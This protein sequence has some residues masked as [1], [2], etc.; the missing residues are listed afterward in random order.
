MTRIVVVVWLGVVAA[1]WAAGPPSLADARTRRLKGNTAEAREQFAA[2]LAD[3]ATRIAAAVGL[4]HCWES[5][6]EPEKARATID[7]AL[8]SGASADLWARS[9]ELLRAA[10]DLDAAAAAAEKALHLQPEHFAARWA[11]AQL[12]RDRGEY[13]KADAEYRWFVRTYV[14]RHRA[15]KDVRDPDE[16][17]IVAQAGAENAR[18]HNLADQFRFILNEVLA[19]ALRA[20]PSYWPAEHLAG[21]LLLEKHNKA[22]ALAA[23]DKAL[24]INPRSADA[25]VGKGRLA[26][27]QADPGEAETFAKRALAVNAR[28]PGALLLLADVYLACGDDDRAVEFLN[29]ARTVN[30]RDEGTLGRLAAVATIR[31]RPNVDA[32]ALRKEAEGFNPK[33]G[34]FYFEMARRLDDRRYYAAARDGYAKALELFPQ[35]TNAKAELG[36]LALRMGEEDRA[37]LLLSDAFKAD[38]FHAR[39]DSSLRVLRHLDKYKTVKTVHFIVRYDERQDPVLGLLLVERLEQE[40]DRLAKKFNHRPAG[41]FVVELFNSHE[42]FSGRIIAA[43]DLH[44]VGATTG[45]VVGMAS[46][47][48]KGVLKPF[49]WS[50]VIRHELTHIFNLDQTN[51]LVPHWLTE[52]LAV[53]NE[54]TPRPPDWLRLL[55]ARLAA[56]ELLTLDTINAGFTRPKSPDDWTLAYCQAQLYVE[57]L[58][59]RFGAE[60][61]ER[62]LK[63]FRAGLT[64]QD[65]LRRACGV[66]PESVESAYKSYVQKVVAEAGLPP[67]ERPLSLAQLEARRKQ[68]VSDP[69]IAAR[70]AEQY[71]RRKRVQEAREL[72]DAAVAKDPAH[73]LANYVRAQLL[74]DAGDVERAAEILESACAGDRP[75]ARS[76]R[77]LGVLH[78]DAGRLEEALAAFE[79][80]RKL[81]PGDPAWSDDIAKAARA[82]GEPERAA[83]AQ[84]TALHFAPDDIDGRRELARAWVELEKFSE[85][86]STA[87]EAIDIDPSDRDVQDLLLAALRRQG[88]SGE[89]DRWERLFARD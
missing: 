80:G 8:K 30:P 70:L 53:T 56:D 86:E 71:L 89:A 62:L 31:R 22:E 49:N 11:R 54:G 60:V 73:G 9:A 20:E 23:F 46:P 14:A 84:A 42:M 77:A 63:E 21:V 81:E 83:R 57:H 78:L 72:A 43:P 47:R 32:D 17:L 45:R 48:A 12:L 13:A 59:Q 2:L 68:D 28:H 75:Y 69:D 40:Y 66:E 37:K 51:F 74:L 15:G 19:D 44:T 4:S 36:L 61:V 1:G 16:L 79:R 76:L 35:L 58:T 41:P 65:A 5:D 33:P 26:L 3:P 6:G 55:A 64:T 10:G 18:W 29:A 88:K 82:A 39:L 27:Q 25:L 67:A 38:P 52:G 50:R 24:A 7:N 34:R 87:R 85:A